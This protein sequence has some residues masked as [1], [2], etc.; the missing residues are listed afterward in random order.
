MVKRAAVIGLGRFGS[1]LARY[2][3]L[4]D[5]EVIA[6]DR[7][8]KFVEA[9]KDDVTLAVRMDSTD[10]DALKA[11]S[12]HDVDVA[13]VGIGQDFES[14]ALTVVRLKELGVAR[15]IARANNDLQAQILQRIGADE[16]ASPENEAASRWA[17][18]LSL[19]GLH[20]YIELGDQ[21]SLVYVAAPSSFHHKALRDLDL[22]N[23]FGVNLVAIRR[24]MQVQ[25]GGE[26]GPVEKAL[27]VVP[28]GQTVV[29]PTDTLIFLGAD[30]DL[31]RLPR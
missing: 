15:V 19:A 16:I 5:V 14:A 3:A 1:R 25:A 22:R 6:I 18:R 17:N 13:V 4:A 7:Q 29:L 8:P 21:H 20:H 30:V 2:L 12:V 10:A 11:H 24:V 26:A 9:I 27:L 23:Q 28:T 31:K